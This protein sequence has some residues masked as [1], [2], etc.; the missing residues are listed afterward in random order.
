MIKKTNETKPLSIYFC[1]VNPPSNCILFQV[2]VVTRLS[3]LYSLAKLSSFC[4]L[5]WSCTYVCPDG[6]LCESWD[7]IVVL[8]RLILSSIAASIFCT[9]SVYS[10]STGWAAEDLPVNCTPSPSLF[11][12]SP[13]LPYSMICCSSSLRELLMGSLNI[14]RKIKR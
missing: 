8:S 3:C 9:S 6:L 11:S 1:W 12:L 7:L 10:S 2:S 13:R 14:G 4:L 5:F